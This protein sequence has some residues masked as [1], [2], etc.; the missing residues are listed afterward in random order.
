M[1][2]PRTEQGPAYGAAILAAVSIG[3]FKSIAQCCSQWVIEED[4][5]LP[6]PV[7]VDKY[8]LQYSK[9]RKLYPALKEFFNFAAQGLTQ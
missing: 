2:R 4:A 9:W 6:E 1:A 5:I 8:N 3:Q 7:L